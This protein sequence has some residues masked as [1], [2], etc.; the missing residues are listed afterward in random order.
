MFDMVGAAPLPGGWLGVWDIVAGA[1]D[2]AMVLAG[3]LFTMGTAGLAL[4]VFGTSKRG[5]RLRQIPVVF[6]AP[7]PTRRSR[8]R[9]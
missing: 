9:R 3:S 8:R 2:L 5:E 7:R 4:A 1:P 6:Q